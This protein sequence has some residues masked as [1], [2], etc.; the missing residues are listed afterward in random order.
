MQ[1]KKTRKRVKPNY[2]GPGFKESEKLAGAAREF[3]SFCIKFKSG[4]PQKLGER[5]TE[6]IKLL[7]SEDGK[8][9]FY[10]KQFKAYR[11]LDLGNSVWNSRW[12]TFISG[13]DKKPL[14]Y[15]MKKEKVEKNI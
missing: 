10:D 2:I 13:G 8:L 11:L 14:K 3:M 5:L 12:V 4:I 1:P 9:R 7:E 6:M 15:N